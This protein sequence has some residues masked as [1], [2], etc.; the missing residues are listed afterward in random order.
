MGPFSRECNRE[1]A[2]GVWD[3]E[4]AHLLGNMSQKLHTRES[5]AFVERMLGRGLSAFGTGGGGAAV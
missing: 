1:T 4:F 5:A 2:A 3:K